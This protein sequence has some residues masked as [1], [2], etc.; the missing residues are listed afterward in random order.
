MGAPLCLVPFLLVGVVCGAAGGK[1]QIG[2]VSPAAAFFPAGL[3]TFIAFFFVGFLVLFFFFFAAMAATFFLFLISTRFLNA[4][5]L[6]PNGRPRPARLGSIGGTF[7]ASLGASSQQMG[8][9]CRH[10][11]QLHLKHKI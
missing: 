5:A 6:R 9:V 2:C 7:Y 8:F 4:A 10:A 3:T 1:K 11:S